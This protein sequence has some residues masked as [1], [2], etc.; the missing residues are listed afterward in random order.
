MKL[1]RLKNAN[2]VKKTENKFTE[3][4]TCSVDMHMENYLPHWLAHGIYDVGLSSNWL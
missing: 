4:Q 3:I 2:C 1:H